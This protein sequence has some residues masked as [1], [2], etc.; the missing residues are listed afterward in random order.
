MEA[1]SAPVIDL[2][3]S[4]ARIDEIDAQIIDL[5]QRRMRIS[6]DVAAYKKATGMQVFDKTREDA[7]VTRARELADDEFKDE[8]LV[9]GQHPRA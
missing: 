8:P 6:R 4:R 7:K 9:P 3:E 5:F 1:A 2:A